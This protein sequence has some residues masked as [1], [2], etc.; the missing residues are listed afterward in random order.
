VPDNLQ[1]SAFV[2]ILYDVSDEIRLEE[3]RRTL[4]ARNADRVLKHA[5]PG[6]LRL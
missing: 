6:Y 5:T 1:A 3:L 4:G 2:L